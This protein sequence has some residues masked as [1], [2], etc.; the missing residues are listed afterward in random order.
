MKH[1]FGVMATIH[2][3]ILLNIKTILKLELIRFYLFAGI[4]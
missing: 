3:A 2:I 1:I 4:G